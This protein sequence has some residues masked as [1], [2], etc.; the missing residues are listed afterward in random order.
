LPYYVW[1]SQRLY[2]R[3]DCFVS[4]DSSNTSVS[5]TVPKKSSWPPLLLGVTLI[6]F[7]VLVTAREIIQVDPYFHLSAGTWI[8]ENGFP[9][10]NVFL[11]N[12][13]DY[14]F[15]DH[16]W[17]YQIALT[18]CYR[19]G[20]FPFLSVAM[21]LATFA[22]V[23]LLALAVPGRRL[24]VWVAI[25][26]FV[27]CS[28]RRFILRPEL[29]GFF[30][31]S[32][33]LFLLERSVLRRRV[34]AKSWLVMLLLYQWL[35]AG[36]HGTFILGPALTLCFL[37]E[38]L[39]RSSKPLVQSLR[40]FGFRP[41]SRGAKRLLGL[42][43]GEIVLSMATPYGLS[44]ALYPFWK[45]LASGVEAGRIVELR[46]PFANLGALTWDVQAFVVTLGFGV[47]GAA[48]SQYRGRGRPAHWCLAFGLVISS[49]SFIRTLPLAAMGLML[50]IIYG[51]RDFSKWVE[52]RWRRGR[53]LELVGLAFLL[54]LNLWGAYASFDGALHRNGLFENRLGLGAA[55]FFQY[56]G[57][58]DFWTRSPPKGKIFNG[59][60]T[61]HYLLFAR[62]GESPRPFI[63]GNTDLYSR[64]F[65]DAYW[66]VMSGRQPFD[67][68]FVKYQ[69]SDVLIDHRTTPGAV[70][71]LDRNPNWDA[72]YFDSQL[73][74]FR[75]KKALNGSDFVARRARELLSAGDEQ[76][77]LG[78][79]EEGRPY[80]G[81][82]WAHFFSLWNHKDTREVALRLG[83]LVH[84][85][86][87]DWIPAIFIHA[88]VEQEAGQ[89]G[90]A[91]EIYQG[92]IKRSPSDVHL[93][94][95][96]ANAALL[97]G[98]SE[99]AIEHY[100]VA[101]E[102]GRLS[103]A[104]D[105]GLS[106]SYLT[107]GSLV[108]LRRYLSTTSMAAEW[109]AYF[110]GRAAARENDV[111]RAFKYYEE[112]LKARPRF[113]E[114]HY[115]LGELYYRNRQF[116]K[117]IRHFE[118]VIELSPKDWEAWEYLG[119]SWFAKKSFFKA[120]RC[121]ERSWTIRPDR[122]RTAFNI[123]DAYFRGQDY[124]NALRW[125]GRVRSTLPAT[126]PNGKMFRQ[127]KKI[128]RVSRA[129]L[130]EQK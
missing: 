62:Q 44:G 27:F 6:L 46:A 60:G 107:S 123:A 65:Y 26:L 90:K 38:S 129:R 43:V 15:V 83:R 87:P 81:L 1:I 86:S 55:R 100:L 40:R 84:E 110:R 57:A 94:L 109:K 82:H 71:R 96:A 30:G 66:A 10:T 50:L 24:A 48:F 19:L 3:H 37:L 23:A 101:K 75:R 4:S 47:F 70:A 28:Y 17:L 61:G 122:S 9:Q 127:L 56:R 108:D 31:V 41:R 77:L 117:G 88:R 89:R 120:A 34:L 12:H 69:I 51:L 128:E 99:T 20:G 52:G 18:L 22:I 42:F 116:L 78:G 114:V 95:A 119:G 64:G 33:H 49:V 72:V 104:V 54:L 125:V 45:M 35:W 5:K 74:I 130:R 92:L 113:T 105:R 67:P 25:T 102:T 98:H 68:Y 124:K 13:R 79:A 93:R 16:E 7:L 112:A 36:S 106:Q 32:L 115:L 126:N 97:A 2:G 8:F 21:I 14:S 76:S 53:L 59:F 111:E 29:V 121:W 91:F 85:K 80:R 63:C 118:E 11:E 39:L 103:A 73:V 58:V